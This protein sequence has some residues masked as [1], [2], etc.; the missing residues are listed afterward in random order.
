MTPISQKSARSIRPGLLSRYK[1][2]G[3]REDLAD[4]LHNATFARAL[5]QNEFNAFLGIEEKG[6]EDASADD[7]AAG[8]FKAVEDFVTEAKGRGVGF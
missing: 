7:V 5:D 3:D 4:W 6:G 1:H 8:F 2:S